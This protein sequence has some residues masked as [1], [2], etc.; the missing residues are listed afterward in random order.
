[1]YSTRSHRAAS[2]PVNPRAGGRTK[3]SAAVSMRF[4]GAITARFSSALP[5]LYLAWAAPFLLTLSWLTP[6]FQN[7][8][9]VNHYLRAVQ[10]A[11]GELVGYRLSGPDW[12]SPPNSGGHSDP[13]VIAA[14]DPFA[15]VKFNP[16]QWVDK[17]DFR[18]ASSWTFGGDE[19]IGFGNTAVYPPFLYLPSVVTVWIGQITKMTILTTLYLSRAANG[20]TALLVSTLAI[21]FACR[22]RWVIAA[23]AM[24]PMTSALY[25]SASQ[26]ALIISLAL[27]LVGIVDRIGT[28]TRPASGIELIAIFLVASLIGMARPPYSVIAVLPLA[29]SIGSARRE[30]SVVIGIVFCI[31]AWTIFSMKV[32]SVDMNGADPGVQITY[33]FRHPFDIVPIAWRTLTDF[34]GN[35]LREFV[36]VLGWLDTALP[37]WFVRGAGIAIAVSLLG[38]CAATPGPKPWVPFVIAV[39]A[40][41]AVF[42]ALYLT[43]TRPLAPFVD[44][45]QGRYFL[46][47]APVA[48]LALPAAPRFTRPVLPLLSMAGII[49]LT[50]LVPA[51]VIRSVV[52]R[53][54]LGG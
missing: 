20:T 16:Q 10:I 25:V 23:M 38:V 52:F 39:L 26:D 7:P 11:R 44:G 49:F 43:W 47:L 28:E 5:T 19:L 14:S 54:Y 51:V 3:R 53:Y 4:I 12:V 17:S 29:I 30:F 35:Y 32:A 8:D 24:L 36:G 18:T 41:G 37:K 22:T 50:I 27:L 45:V 42:G 21:S 48:A 46:P 9:E 15:H 13:G 40:S 33:I 34:S 2:F 6:P 1:L 31:A